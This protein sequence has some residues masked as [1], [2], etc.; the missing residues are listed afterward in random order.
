MKTRTTL[1]AACLVAVATFAFS[2]SASAQTPTPPARPAAAR[3]AGERLAWQFTRIKHAQTAQAN[4]IA[5]MK[6]LLDRAQARIDDAKARG[7]DVA[8]LQTALD[9][10]KKHW[11][12]AQ[13]ANA[14]ASALIAA[15]AGFDASGAVSDATAARKT[16]ADAR[17]KLTDAHRD[18][19]DGRRAIVDALRDQRRK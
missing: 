19:A 10:G 14:D 6:Q 17:E 13:Q 3:P 5:R 7:R 1:M 4:H 9:T 11:Q 2:G 15:H 18:L 12:S 16:L 8:A